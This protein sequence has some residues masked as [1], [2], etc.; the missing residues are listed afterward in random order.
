[1][2]YDEAVAGLSDAT[3]YLS[4]LYEDEMDVFFYY[5]KNKGSAAFQDGYKH[6]FVLTYESTSGRYIVSYP[7]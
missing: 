7:S 6:R 4:A 1:M 3:Y 5:A 2:W